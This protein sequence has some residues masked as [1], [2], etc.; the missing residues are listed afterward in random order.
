MM[1]ESVTRRAW[2]HDRKRM[3]SSV[4]VVIM[5]VLVSAAAMIVSSDRPNAELTI[6]NVSANPAE[7]RVD[8]D[9]EWTVVVDLQYNGQRGNGLLFT[10]D[11][12]DG[13][14]TVNHMASVNDSD[15]AIDV[16]THAWAESGLYDVVVSVWDGYGS[17]E[18][19]C[20][21]VSA[22]VS[23]VVNEDLIEVSDGTSITIFEQ[24]GAVYSCT[25]PIDTLMTTG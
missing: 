20:Q 19:E 17:D 11:W 4:I 24:T 12:D 25:F 3:M 15:I 8:Q 9:V 1:S 2:I 5:L 7:A 18:S 10:W 22:T 21:N 23:F 16:Q 13:T 6:A 14:Y